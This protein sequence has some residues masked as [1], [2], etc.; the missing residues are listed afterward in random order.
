M[1]RKRVN[2]ARTVRIAGTS[3]LHTYSLVEVEA[4]VWFGFADSMCL[5]RW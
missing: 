3:L 2:K 4:V 1:E 5:C